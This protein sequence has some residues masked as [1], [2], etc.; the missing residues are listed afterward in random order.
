MISSHMDPVKKT[1]ILDLHM[2]IEDLNASIKA[3]NAVQAPTLGQKFRRL[4]LE[5]RKAR[6]MLTLR[7]L[8]AEPDNITDDMENTS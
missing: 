7:D 6:I 1:R 5:K 4:I 2:K 3:F 8:L